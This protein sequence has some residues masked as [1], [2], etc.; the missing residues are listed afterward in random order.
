MWTRNTGNVHLDLMLTSFIC[1]MVPIWTHCQCECEDFFQL[2]WNEYVLSIAGIWGIRLYVIGISSLHHLANVAPWSNRPTHSR[3]SWSASPTLPMW[4][5]SASR[6]IVYI[7]F[8]VFLNQEM[9]NLALVPFQNRILMFTVSPNEITSIVWSY[10]LWLPQYTMNRCNA[11]MK[12]SVSILCNISIWIARIF[13]QVT[14]QPWA[15]R[16]A[17]LWP[18]Y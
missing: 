6:G 2:I 15:L 1:H 16:G 3:H 8:Y 13:R 5:L 4:L 12:E 18:F 7:P 11:L 14:I 10:P 17:S 9:V